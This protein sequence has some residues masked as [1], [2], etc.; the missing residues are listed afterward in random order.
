MQLACSAG[1]LP[2]YCYHIILTLERANREH[3]R[4]FVKGSVVLCLLKERAVRPLYPL[5][6]GVRA[7]LKA[8]R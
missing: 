7:S 5:S 6:G 3:N 8:L 2:A 1:Q 4:G